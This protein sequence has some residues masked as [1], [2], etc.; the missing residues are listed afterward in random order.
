MF[1]QTL[2]Q[3]MERTQWFRQAFWQNSHLG[4][5]Q[6]SCLVGGYLAMTRIVERYPR[7]LD[8]FNSEGYQPSEWAR[9]AKAAGMHMILTATPRRFLPLINSG[10]TTR[11]LIL[12]G[13]LVGIAEAARAEGPKVAFITLDWHHPTIHMPATLSP[14][15]HQPLIQV[16][17]IAMSII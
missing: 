7:Y 5:L 16:I 6:H 4:A 14:C 3:I 12:R 10:R 9:Q 8:C 1:V 13:R 15:K 11:R 17:S 2:D